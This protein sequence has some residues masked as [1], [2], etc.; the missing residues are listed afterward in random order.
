MIIEIADCP[1]PYAATELCPNGRRI[2]VVA[3][4]RD[5]VG[6]HAGDSDSLCRSKEALGRGQVAVLAMA[7]P[8]WSTGSA[9]QLFM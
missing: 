6:D 8:C 3:I 1:V 7:R 2:G 4:R 9:A 5:P